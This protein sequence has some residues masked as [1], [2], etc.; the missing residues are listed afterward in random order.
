MSRAAKTLSDEDRVLWNTVA[1]TATPLKG[2]PLPVEPASKPRVAEAEQ[3]ARATVDAPP[4]PSPAPAAKRRQNVASHLD[5]QTRD[6]LAK[7]RLQIEGRVDL[8]GMTQDEAYFLLLSFLRRA[9][10]SDVRYVL[11]IT[12]KGSRGDGILRRAVPGW[13]T[14]PPFRALV[15][16]HDDA[17]RQHGGGGAIY[18]RIRKRERAA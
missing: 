7:G 12:G 9:F 2:R 5:K 15:S 4:A 16:S 6:K 11:V 17:A 3:P 8:H 10:E 1:R 14:T 13:L 18:V